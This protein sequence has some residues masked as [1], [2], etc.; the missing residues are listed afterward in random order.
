MNSKE[1]HCAE[2]DFFMWLDEKCYDNDMVIVNDM[3]FMVEDCIS[4]L[5]GTITEAKKNTNQL[6]VKTEDNQKYILKI[7]DENSMYA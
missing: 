1:N 3:P 2:K 4:I 6:I 5:Q 7:F